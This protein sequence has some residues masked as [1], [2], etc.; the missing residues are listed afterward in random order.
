M[1]VFL[2]QSDFI[3]RDPRVNRI[4]T[5]WHQSYQVTER[6]QTRRNHVLL[7]PEVI[8]GKAILDLGCC[9]AASGGWALS[10]GASS[11]TGVEISPELATISRENLQ[12]YHPDRS[13]TII[14]SSVENFLRDHSA[15]YD[16]VL[17]AGILYAIS[18]S[19]ESIL[20]I[21]NL[22]DTMMIEGMHPRKPPGLDVPEISEEME[23]D[24]PYVFY[25]STGM[26]HGTNEEDVQTLGF[27]ASIGALTLMNKKIGFERD[28]TP[29]NQLCRLLPDIYSSSKRYAVRFNRIGESL[30]V[31]YNKLM[32]S[33]RKAV[34]SWKDV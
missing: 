28:L 11:Y 23:L 34:K 27:F 4:K 26:C 31:T 24:Y 1:K 2:E 3:D 9:V 33:D 10:Y 12:R 16:I 32:N 6:I 8:E 17:A 5:F 29:Y 14:E 19:M 15:R 25:R 20:R 22:T 21:A 7:P 13:W 18:D 30:P